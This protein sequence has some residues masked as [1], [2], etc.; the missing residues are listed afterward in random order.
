MANY[1]FTLG[2]LNNIVPPTYSHAI[3]SGTDPAPADIAATNAL[4]TDHKVAV[5]VINAQ[6]ESPVTA[7]LAQVAK[8][9]KVPV[10]QVT[11]TLP[12]GVSDYVTWQT[13]NVEA[14]GT[15]LNTK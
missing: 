2:G 14:L 8:D 4:V 13:D 10:V 7:G 12:Q 11:E 15:A 5:V 9:A 6:T 3:E 1:L